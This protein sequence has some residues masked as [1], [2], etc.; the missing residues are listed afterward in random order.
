MQVVEE[1]KDVK[2][3]CLNRNKSPQTFKYLQR[4]EEVIKTFGSSWWCDSL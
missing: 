2:L 3:Q 4:V 1:T